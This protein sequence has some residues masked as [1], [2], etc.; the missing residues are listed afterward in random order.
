MSE[1]KL[2]V[3]CGTD[4]A[5]KKTQTS[6]LVDRLGS[7]GF[8]VKRISFP[9]YG[10]PAAVMSERYLAG[11][12]GTE[13]DVGPYQA[14]TYY[15]HDRADAAPLVR[16]W[17]KQGGI[18]MSDR[19]VSDNKGHQLGKI[20]NP[21]ERDRFLAWLNWFEYEC[22]GVVKEDA[23]ILLYLPPEIGKRRAERRAEKQAPGSKLDIHE[24]NLEHLTRAA[25]AYLYAAKKEGWQIIDCAPGGIELDELE[26]HRMLY[27]HVRRILI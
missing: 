5:G 4:G 12:F 19:Y 26:I 9:R 13:A 20:K 6:M 24:N 21:A 15:A 23:T 2:I 10:A 1:G 8:K 17:I 7:E 3:L 22:L 18:W 27:D 11:E 14:S 25:E 16:S